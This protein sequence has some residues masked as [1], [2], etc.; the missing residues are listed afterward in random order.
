M[1]KI[2]IWNFMTKRNQKENKTFEKENKIKQKM[3][4]EKKTERGKKKRIIEGETKEDKLS[5]KR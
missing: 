5:G 1:Q 3:G 2:I 4:N